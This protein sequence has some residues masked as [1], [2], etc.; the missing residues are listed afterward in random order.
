MRFKSG[1]RQGADD[2]IF[3][4]VCYTILTILGLMV[5]Y[6]LYFIVISSFSD[7]LQ[8]FAGKVVF[9]PKGLNIDGYIRIFNDDSILVGYRNSIVYTILGTILSVFLTISVAYPLSRKYFS[10]RGIIMTFLLITMYFSGGMIPSYLLIKQLGLL[11]TWSV[12]VIAGAVSTY[13]IIIT[14]SFMTEGVP[15][16]LEEAASIDGCSQLQFFMTFVIPLSKAVIAVL[17]LYYGVAQWNNFMKALLYINDS[18]KFPLQLILRSLLLSAQAMAAKNLTEE[19]M[20]MV[21]KAQN[22]AEAMKYAII[23][24]SSLP[25][26]VIYPFLQKYFVQGAMIGSV[27]G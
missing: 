9:L 14:R 18:K 22:E 21:E 11:D 17:V 24:V 15:S 2:L 5:L 23:I 20:A 12:F 13:N 19:N 7:P 26:L 6:P 1:V 10:C 16:E 27:K 25:V 4:I 8:I 3:D